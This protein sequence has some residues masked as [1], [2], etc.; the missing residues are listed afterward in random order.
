MYSEVR[1]PRRGVE[2]AELQR[3]GDDDLAMVEPLRAGAL[4]VSTSR[5]MRGRASIVAQSSIRMPA[6]SLTRSVRPWCGTASIGGQALARKYACAASRSA[7][8][9]TRK[10]IR[11][12]VGLPRAGASTRL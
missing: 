1:K 8:M 12:Q 7:S 11:L 6:G 9:K 3:V 5:N 10:P 4:C 2:A